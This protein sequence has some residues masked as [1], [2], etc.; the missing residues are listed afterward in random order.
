[1]AQ[2]FEQITAEIGLVVS[3]I[4]RTDLALLAGYSQAKAAAIARFT[5]VLGEGYAA[6]TISEAQLER[7]KEELERMVIRF[8]RNLQALATTTIE[9]IISGVAD[10]LMA[11]LRQMTGLPGLT[12]APTPATI[13]G[14]GPA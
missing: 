6:G 7:E 11:A 5:V 8:V 3:R 12:L 4:A 10:V 9:R 14:V 1:M 2:T 13:W